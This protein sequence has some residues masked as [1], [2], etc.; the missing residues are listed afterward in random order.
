MIEPPNQ[1]NEG[2]RGFNEMFGGLVRGLRSQSYDL[3]QDAR[4]IEQAWNEKDIDAL[5]QLRAIDGDQAHELKKILSE[6]P[7]PEPT[8]SLDF[9]V[10]EDP[11]TGELLYYQR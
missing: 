11:V 3:A 9:D 10:H 6:P 5:L 7:P 2:L 8:V 4:L 1:P